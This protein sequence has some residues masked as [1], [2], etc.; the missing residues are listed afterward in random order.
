[1]QVSQI[2]QGTLGIRYPFQTLL[3]DGIEATVLPVGL[4]V[5]GL[6]SSTVIW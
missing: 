3:L 6:P 5:A 1:M 4:Q 2:H